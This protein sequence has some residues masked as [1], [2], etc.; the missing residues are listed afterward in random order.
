MRYLKVDPEEVA[1]E[2][3]L[4]RALEA[5]RLA[6][7][8]ELDVKR[9]DVSR[10]PRSNAGKEQREAAISEAK[11]AAAA[12][13]KQAKR[14]AGVLAPKQVKALRRQELHR[15]LSN[16]EAAHAADTA[17]VV[18]L[19]EL[20]A[21]DMTDQEALDLDVAEVL[22]PNVERWIGLLRD[23]LEKVE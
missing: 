22:L 23:E 3:R 13:R 6:F 8:Q 14:M 2:A 18:E 5:E 19:S 9:L 15:M 4:H 11:K 21:N 1:A 16:L 17:Y 20:D 10:K 12:S 7:T